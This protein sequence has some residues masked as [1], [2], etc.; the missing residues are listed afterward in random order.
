MPVRQLPVT[1]FAIRVLLDSIVDYAGLYPPAAVSMLTAVRSFAHYRAGE[2]GWMLGRFIC[3]AASLEIFSRDAEMYLPRDAGAIAWQLS[4]TSSGNVEQDMIAIAAFNERHR[5]CFD[6][7]NASVD[8]YEVKATT[9]DEVRAINELVPQKLR[10]FIEVPSSANPTAL[11]EAIANA[12]RRAKIRTGGITADAFPTSLQVAQFLESCA[13]T[14]VTAKATAGLHHPLR[15]TY[16]L[17][18]EDNAPVGQMFG[19]LNI[20]LATALVASG[21]PTRDVVAM[22]EE[23]NASRISFDETH[24]LWKGGTRPYSIDRGF[25]AQMRE[26]GLVSFGSCSFTEPVNETRALGWL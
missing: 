25:L 7:C 3:P 18:Y 4:A 11:L 13:H 1:D 19:Y 16:R 22:L 12:G 15:A 21:A 20:F 8:S 23:S 5:V 9:V 17:T 2:N 6:E 14:G 24:C 10:T 26:R